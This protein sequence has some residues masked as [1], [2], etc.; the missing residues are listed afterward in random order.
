M[1]TQEEQHAEVWRRLNATVIFAP[2]VTQDPHTCSSLEAEEPLVSAVLVILGAGGHE[3]YALATELG[4]VL[5][6]ESAAT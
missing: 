3:G 2:Q 6:D 1:F 5:T 4:D